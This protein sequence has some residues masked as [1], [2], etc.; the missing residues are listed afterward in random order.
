MAVLELGFSVEVEVSRF[1]KR[2]N[3]GAQWNIINKKMS[4]GVP[5]DNWTCSGS[6]SSQRPVTQETLMKDNTMAHVALEVEP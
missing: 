4:N 1:W 5:V 2:A 3:L 6:S